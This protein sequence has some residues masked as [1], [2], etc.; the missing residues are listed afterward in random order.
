MNQPPAG[1]LPGAD[2]ANPPGDGG[3][4]APPD[5]DDGGGAPADRPAI[6]PPPEPER[7]RSARGNF[8]TFARSGGSDRGALR[9][10]VRDYV[11]SGTRGSGNAVRRM[12]AS[13]AT[14]SGALGV[15]RGFQRDGVAG[16]LI[17][18]NLGNLVGRSARDVFLG[19]TD[20]ICRDGGSIDEAIARDAWLETVAELERFDIDN[21][22][23]LTTD[24]VKELFLTFVT[25]AVETRLFQEIGVNGFKVA[26][27]SAI[28]TFEA[29]FR[30]YI[31]RSIRDS[32]ASDLSQLS[33]L[34]DQQIR[35][36]VDRTYRDAWELLVIWGDQ[37]G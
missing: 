21:L 11:R 28:E 19:L 5:A 34:S 25:H 23:A 3:D 7:F 22:D 1:P 27:L 30:S 37:P 32:F 8:S 18:L 33:G 17:R 26:D 20:V 29:Q 2:P 14:A 24:Q 13:R 4:Q 31:E 10:A 36:I 12:G 35:T 15:F 16:T 9:R 6:Q